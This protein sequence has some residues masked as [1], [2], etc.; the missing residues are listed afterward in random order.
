MVTSFPSGTGSARAA[1][2][3]HSGDIKATYTQE[4]QTWRSPTDANIFEQSTTDIW[5]AI[6]KC[7][8]TVLQESG[9]DPA[10]VKGVGFDAT[11]SLA[12]TDLQG[13]PVTVTG[14]PTLGSP[15][16]RDIILWA[17]HRASKEAKLINST[18]SEVLKYVGGTMSVRFPI[19][20]KTSA[21]S[22]RSRSWKWKFRRPSGL[23]ITWLQSD[24]L[25]ASSSIFQTSVRCVRYIQLIYT[26]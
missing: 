8:R 26:I 7:T 22:D 14:G 13:N 25:S 11:C 12:V 1:L 18:G 4:T 19:T 5:S 24:S 20:H 2:I 16:E 15:G 21:M 9:I 10:Q 17:D 3:S 6:A 23:R